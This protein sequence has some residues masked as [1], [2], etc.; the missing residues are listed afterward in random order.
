MEDKL[1]ETVYTPA[2][3]AAMLKISRATVYR[4]ISEGDL[5]VVRFRGTTRILASEVTRLL[6][7]G[8]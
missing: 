1:Q 8:R 6:E 7:T 2:E 4:M 5:G 3:V